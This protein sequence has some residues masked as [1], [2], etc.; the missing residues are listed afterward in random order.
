MKRALFFFLATVTLVLCV[1]TLSS[2]KQNKWMNFY[3]RNYYDGGTTIERVEGGDVICTVYMQADSEYDVD[4]FKKVKIKYR[5]LDS[6]GDSKTGLKTAKAYAPEGAR[7]NPDLQYFT[8]VVK[9]DDIIMS[10]DQIYVAYAKGVLKTDETMTDD[11]GVPSIFMTFVM[12]IVL[13]VVALIV[14][15]MGL[16]ARD[17]RGLF[18][19]VLANAAP[20][21]LN[22]GMY[23]WW[24]AARG[25]II[26]VFC[27][28]T[29]ALTIVASRY[30]D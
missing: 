16:A 8:F 29:I 11:D 13:T 14:A 21:F 9:Y 23:F 26:S 10:S 19:V 12:G 1:F 18:Y 7:G 27:A 17:E 6:T 5:V 28:A 25:I 2:C 3:T 30:I 24:G 22:I 15:C 4:D 20:I